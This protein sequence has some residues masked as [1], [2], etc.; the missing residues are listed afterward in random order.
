MKQRTASFLI[1]GIFVAGLFASVI[2]SLILSS[3]SPAPLFP[4]DSDKLTSE[5][6]ALYGA[7]I[8]VMFGGTLWTV[9]SDKTVPV[10]LFGAFFVIVLLWNLMAAEPVFTLLLS[11]TAKI[12]ACIA[13][14]QLLVERGSFLI[15]GALTY[16]YGS[17]KEQKD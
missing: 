14:Q 15:S 9:H 12:D 16:F 7:P 11:S 3:G 4:S 10:P 5:L 13:S 6:F 8:G 17:G 1:A 2:A